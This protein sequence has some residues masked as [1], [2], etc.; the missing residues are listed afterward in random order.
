MN[1]SLA[2]LNL[3]ASTTLLACKPDPT[4]LTPDATAAEP[5]S[6]DE[7][8]IEPATDDGASE[9]VAEGGGEAAEPGTPEAGKRYEF[10]VSFY[11]PGD[12]TDGAAFERLTAIVKETPG[13]TQVTGRWGREGEHD[14][15]FTL[16][17]LG[18]PERAAFIARVRKE[19]GNSKK[20]NIS[21][22]A[23]CQHNPR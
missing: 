23:E 5:T 14:E 22:N 19:V 8:A 16:A 21:E 17:G 1:R 18:A 15:C 7:G 3:V 13:L 9:P 6:A 4:T 2:V 10:V 12:G 11:S 20:V